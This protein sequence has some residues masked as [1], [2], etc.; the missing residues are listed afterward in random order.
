MNL[1]SASSNVSRETLDRLHAYADLVRRWNPRINLVAASTLSDLWER[2]VVDS[3]QVFDHADRTA[4]T[5]ADLGSGGGL[6]GIVC[7]ILAL[8]LMPD[9]SFTLVESD[10]RKAAF[11]LV[12]KQEFALNLTVRIERAER[13]APLSAQIVSA[14]ALAPLPQLLPLVARHIASGGCAL[15][16]KGKNHAA[17]LE[18]ARAEWHFQVTSHVSTT[19]AWARILALKDIQRV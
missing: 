4:T 3:M 19:D 17:E 2:H 12:C 14:R 11:L 16:P 18:A 10:K 15:L 6:P 13:L 7:A 5:W 9:C 1:H 8:E